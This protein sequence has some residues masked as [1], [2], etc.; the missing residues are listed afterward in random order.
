MS[1]LQE[2][3]VISGWENGIADSPHLGVGLIRN[4]DIESF[5]GAVKVQK[6]PLTLFHSVSTLTFTASAA[7]DTCTAS[8]TIEANGANFS[9]AAVY[10]TTTGTL[11]AGLSTGT[12]YF[13]YKT[14]NN[15]FQVATTYAN[16]VG[17]TAGTVI[18]I[19]DA[20]TGTHTLHQVAIGKINHILREPRTGYDYFLDDDGRV[21]FDPGADRAYLLHNS[22]IEDP[23][24]SLTNASGNGLAISAFSSTS[25]TYL[26][27][28]RNAVIDVIDIFGDANI[29]ALTWSNA[30]QSLNTAIGVANSHQAIKAQDDVIYFCDARYVG[31]ILENA[32]STFDPANSATYTYNNQALD[33]PALEIAQCLEE[34]GPELL[35]GGLTFN[36]I[37]PWNRIADSFSFPL[38]VPEI[39]I[40]QMENIGEIVYILAGVAGIVYA[41]QGTY[42]RLFKRLPRHVTNNA[43]TVQSS[44]VTWGGIAQANGLL[45]FGVG[46]ITSGASGTYR[47]YD[48][49]RLI[50]DSTPS[51]GSTNVTAILAQTNFYITGYDG[52]GD[53]FDTALQTTGYP[54]VLQS[55][56]YIV[57]TK[58]KKAT[59]SELEVQVGTPEVTGNVR[60]SY[61]TDKK[62]SFTVLATFTTTTSVVSFT[63]N[64]GLIDLE[65]IQIQ[66]ELQGSAEFINTTLYP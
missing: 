52:G 2:P 44:Q 24:G 61:R 33:L 25:A 9:G 10:F 4:A 16:S 38:A 49:G 56:L 51:T 48:D 28:F 8:G 35:I 7:S 27:V 64:I 17:S 53:R 5:P 15:T 36:K 47:L 34:L 45:L 6:L 30:W 19:T 37:Y 50:H 18:D 1:S 29:E 22:A 32:G 66:I 63:T 59:Y 55:A 11:P 14:A 26:F 40:R 60:V 31:S 43:H 42:V 12:V 3:L 58:I 20:G 57:G 13:L 62:S 41:T 39:G 65:K 54:T 23:D 21:W 46:A